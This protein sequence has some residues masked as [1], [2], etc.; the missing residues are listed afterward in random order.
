MN[1]TKKAKQDAEIGLFRLWQSMVS[2]DA[3]AAEFIRDIVIKASSYLSPD[4][5]KVMLDNS[6]RMDA[7]PKVEQTIK[8]L[9]YHSDEWPFVLNSIHELRKVDLEK[10]SQMKIGSR[11]VIKPGGA[12]SGRSRKIETNSPA[13]FALTIY[14][15]IQAHRKL[16]EFYTTE[17]LAKL[18]DFP[19]IRTEWFSRPD[20]Q[21]DAEKLPN[22]DAHHQTQD[23]WVVVMVEVVRNM[24]GGNLETAHCP[25]FI[26]KRARQMIANGS[27]SRP[28]EDAIRESF[29]KGIA[30]LLHI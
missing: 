4:H 25:A 15:E 13:G 5:C 29:E 17:N 23:L 16:A 20:W 28:I 18:G 26:H 11:L 9:A 12:G 30:A 8:A 2:G 1:E 10:F 14:R 19:K 22:L 6:E 24:A 27:K 21:L 3:E 7:F